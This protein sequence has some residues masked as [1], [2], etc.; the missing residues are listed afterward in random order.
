MNLNVHPCVQAEPWSTQSSYNLEGARSIN[1][2]QVSVQASVVTALRA[3]RATLLQ[4]GSAPEIPAFS[5]QPVTLNPLNT[6]QGNPSFRMESQVVTPRASSFRRTGG[7]AR[8]S[9]RASAE[10]RIPPF[11]AD[12][13]YQASV[14]LLVSVCNLSRQQPLRRCLMSDLSGL[15]RAL[16]RKGLIL[17]CLPSMLHTISCC[18]Y[19]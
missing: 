2:R 16:S 11:L 13:Q 7:Q 5:V 12:G 6:Q 19:S 17:N 9:F 14:Y 15:S 10:N 3:D 8:N 1:A 18:L 4:S